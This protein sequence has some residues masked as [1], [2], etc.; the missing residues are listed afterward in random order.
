MIKILRSLQNVGFVKGD[1]K[2]LDHCHIT[3]KYRGA[4][5][6]DSYINVSLN[7]K[8]PIMFQNRE[9]YE[10]H[11]IMQELGKYSFI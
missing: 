5:H 11:L 9:N 6:R 1:F 3:G 10:A 4:A 2:I 7:C 8:I